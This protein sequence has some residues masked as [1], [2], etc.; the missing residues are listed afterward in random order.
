MNPAESVKNLPTVFPPSYWLDKSEREEF[1]VEF[2]RECM[3]LRLPGFLTPE[4]YGGLGRSLEDLVDVVFFLGEH[5]FGT[6]VYPLLSNNM[7]SLVLLNSG[8]EKLA[9]LFLPKLAMGEYIMGLAITEKT[10]GSDVLSI[11]TKAEYRNGVYVVNGEKMFV[12][13]IDAATHM[14]LAAR[15][16]PADKAGKRSEGLTLFILDLKQEGVSFQP[17]PKTGTNYYKTG[18]MTLKDVEI[19]GER[20]VGP[21]GRGWKTLTAAL[22]PDRIVYAA[23]GAGSALYAVKTA[24]AHAVERVVFGKPVGS[25]QGIQL[26]LAENYTLAEAARLLCIE[27]ARAYDRGERAD[28]LACMAK[29]MASEVAVK[30]LTHAMQVLGGYGYLKERHLERVLRDMLLLKS[31]PITQELALAYVAERGLMLPRSY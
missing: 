27:A 7:S 23:L 28:V 30:S 12:N 1:P 29:Y 10:S 25:Y 26:P 15:T 13:N 5:G 11:T 6:G 16:T 18:M 2:W 20:V 4:K 19:S 9:E 3:R 21:V 14:L 17:L 8:D 31:G 24:S 22:N